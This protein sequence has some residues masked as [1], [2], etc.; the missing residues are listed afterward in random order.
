ME[1]MDCSPE[2]ALEK[3]PL[4]LTADV[5]YDIS[6]VS[7]RDLMQLSTGPHFTATRDQLQYK[8]LRVLEILEALVTERQL[9]PEQDQSRLAM[10]CSSVL[11]PAAA[12]SG[13]G[14]DFAAPSG[15]A[16][17]E[18]GAKGA[19]TE[20]AREAPRDGIET[21]S[22]ARGVSGAERER[23]AFSANSTIRKTAPDKNNA[24]AQHPSF[25]IPEG[26]KM[27]VA[28]STKTAQKGREGETAP[29]LPPSP[30]S[31]VHNYAKTGTG[32]VASSDPARQP[33][34][35]VQRGRVVRTVSDTKI[36]ESRGAERHSLLPAFHSPV[37]GGEREKPQLVCL[38]SVVGKKSFVSPS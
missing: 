16:V 32:G 23:S 15:V 34:C 6:T 1:D 14:T 19:L 38:L 21:G 30:A 28:A 3:S 29:S 17:A 25:P 27:Q 8:I 10:G 4:Q 36:A 2:K 26:G 12:K 5:V 24:S 31:A 7:G 9:Q 35:P 13:A 20:I 33:A 37:R 11:S 22:A 18:R